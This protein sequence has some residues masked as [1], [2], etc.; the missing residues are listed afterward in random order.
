MT[1][2]RSGPE[3]PVQTGR[4][5]VF[6]RPPLLRPWQVA[7]FL[8]GVWLLLRYVGKTEAE[9]GADSLLLLALWALGLGG[10]VFLPMWTEV[11]IDGTARQVHERTG[12]FRWATGKS[13][14]LDNFEAVAVVRRTTERHEA[15]GAPGTTFNTVRRWH[16]TE[17]RLL[18]RRP[19]PFHDLDLPLPRHATRDQIQALAAE[20]AA[21]GG[22]PVRGPE[23]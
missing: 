17:F 20:V 5:S 15:T 9:P 1:H 14:P 23:A 16:E 12:W 22:W 3:A 8:F 18:L 11:V 19:Q 6:S 4:R 21:M 10:L 2:S 7:L 13:S